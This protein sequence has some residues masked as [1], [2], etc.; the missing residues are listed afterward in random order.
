M[1][2]VEGGSYPDQ[3]EETSLFEEALKGTAKHKHVK[4]SDVGTA[5]LNHLFREMAHSQPTPENAVVNPIPG[6]QEIQ[7]LDSKV[8]KLLNPEK[9][10]V[11]KVGKGKTPY[12]IGQKISLIT[13]SNRQIEVEVIKIEENGTRFN[14]TVKKA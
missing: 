1:T 8:D 4:K 3:D 10:I 5:S 2:N 14:L 13:N 11:I 6:L 7:V 9:E 12:T